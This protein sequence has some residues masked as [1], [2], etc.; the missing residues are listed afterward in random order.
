MRYADLMDDLARNHAAMGREESVYSAAA[1]AIRQLLADVGAGDTA[2]S[3]LEH[4]AGV[5]SRERDEARNAARLI[6]ARRHNS[7]FAE[8][9][10]I[11][12]WPWLKKGDQG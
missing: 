12:E 8:E 3:Q 1:A 5:L 6:M 4:Q 9:C 2:I 11:D 7:A 10:W